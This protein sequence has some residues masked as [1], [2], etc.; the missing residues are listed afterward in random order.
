MYMP[1]ESIPPPQQDVDVPVPGWDKTARLA[2][3]HL[4]AVL[5]EGQ[6]C[7]VGC[8]KVSGHALGLDVLNAPPGFCQ[9]GGCLVVLVHPVLELL[10]QAPDGPAHR[11]LPHLLGVGLHVGGGGSDLQKLHQVLAAHVRVLAAGLLQDGHWVHRLVLPGQFDRRPVDLL[12]RLQGEILHPEQ[13]LHH[14][15]APAIQQD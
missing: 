13:G 11:L 1:L 5:V 9:D 2:L 3:L 10:P 12:V 6:E 15:Q 8:Q 4:S 7:I 14:R